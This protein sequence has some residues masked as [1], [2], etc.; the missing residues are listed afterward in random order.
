MILEATGASDIWYIDVISLEEMENSIR[1]IPDG[2]GVYSS[3]QNFNTRNDRITATPANPV[4][5][6]PSTYVL[7]GGDGSIDITFTWTY[8]GSG[9]AY[10]IDGFSIYTHSSDTC[11]TPYFPSDSAVCG[12]YYKKGFTV[13]NHYST[14][15]TL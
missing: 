15:T 4:V 13:W 14:S 12:C 6:T 7:N 10:N 3:S 5:T 1:D 2:E 9:D 8:V 11:H